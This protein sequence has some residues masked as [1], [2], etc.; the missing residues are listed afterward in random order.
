MKKDFYENVKV[1]NNNKMPNG[2]IINYKTFL[3]ELQEKWKWFSKDEIL[4]CNET[5]FRSFSQTVITAF[6]EFLKNLNQPNNTKNNE[7]RFDVDLQHLVNNNSSDVTHINKN[8]YLH[9]SQK[10][11]IT[12]SPDFEHE[13]DLKENI[14][15]SFI[16]Y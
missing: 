2:K 12:D 5:T 14:G 9:N 3:N 16:I 15:N 13:V 11:K 6:N 10:K 7:I 8:G 4:F 1:A